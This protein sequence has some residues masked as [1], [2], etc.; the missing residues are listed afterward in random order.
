MV[1]E[2]VLCEIDGPV[3]LVT[4]NRPDARNAISDELRE[5]LRSLLDTLSGNP[6]IRVVVFT[7]AGSAFCA[8]GDVRAMRERLQS[9][10]GSVAFDGWRRQQRT[11]ALSAAIHHLDQVTIAAVNGPAVG[12]GF[13]LALACDF[14]VASSEAMF[15]ASFIARGLVSDGGGLYH[16]PRRVGMQRAKELL[17]SGR[18][19]DAS[20]AA[21]LGIVDAVASNRSLLEEVRAFAEPFTHQPRA[22][23]SLM[24][25]ILSRSFEQTLEGI[26]ALGSEAQAIC[27]STDDHRESVE[28]FLAPKP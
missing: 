1:S 3:A 8:G 23:L 7:G 5:A 21:S 27:Y 4:L 18:R 20:E 14:I 24:K 15:S 28:A 19:V 2:T 10:P 6:A 13:D 17:F 11:F 26:G 12:L 16:L 9:P 25:S 22:A